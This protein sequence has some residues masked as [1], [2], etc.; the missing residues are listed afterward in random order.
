MA[1]KN[2]STDVS[3]L[4]LSSVD[5]VNLTRCWLETVGRFE[6]YKD[7]DKLSVWANIQGLR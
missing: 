4:M 2:T 3:F 5:S 1:S 7:L 6:D